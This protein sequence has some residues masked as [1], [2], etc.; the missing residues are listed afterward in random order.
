LKLKESTLQDLK[1]HPELWII[2]E[3]KPEFSK[4]AFK[5]LQIDY[6][7]SLTRPTEVGLSLTLIDI[8][9]HTFQALIKDHA[10]NPLNPA[11]VRLQ[12]TE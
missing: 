7:L 8:S 1:N 6:N 5:A 12:R 4:G 2:E 3:I 11:M 10:R 9:M